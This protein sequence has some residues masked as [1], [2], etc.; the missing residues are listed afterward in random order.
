MRLRRNRDV[1]NEAAE[2]GTALMAFFTALGGMIV[3]VAQWFGVVSVDALSQS[4]DFVADR[5]GALAGASR[6]KA[7]SATKRGNRAVLKLGLIAL[8]L[9]W[10]DRDLSQ[11]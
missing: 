2:F 5:G 8:F 7:R 1:S 6:A 4:A 11:R 10:L 9:W 3:S